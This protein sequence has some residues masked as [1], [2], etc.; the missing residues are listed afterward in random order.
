M[1]RKNK[2]ASLWVHN[3]K[4]ARKERSRKYETKHSLLSEVKASNTKAIADDKAALEAFYVT[5][6]GIAA[7]G[8][9]AM[10]MDPT[11]C[12][13]CIGKVPN[14]GTLTKK[15]FRPQG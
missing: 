13:C 7:G 15:M 3:V 2:R 5:H 6:P 1:G 12:A 4:E 9:S 11:S 8:L 14:F 10:G